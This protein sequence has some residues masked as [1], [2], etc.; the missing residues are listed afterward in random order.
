MLPNLSPSRLTG[1]WKVGLA[2]SFRNR[3]SKLLGIW[4]RNCQNLSQEEKR[5]VIPDQGYKFVKADQAGA[6]ALIVAWLCRDGNL[7]QLFLNK[8]KLHTYVTAKIFRNYWK[9]EGHHHID[10]ILSLPVR[11][12]KQFHAWAGLEKAIKASPIRYFIGKKTGL[13]ANYRMRGPTFQQ[14]ILRESEGKVVISRKEADA[15]LDGYHSLFPEIREWHANSIDYKLKHKLAFRN[16]FGHP[17]YYYG[18]ITEK[19]MRDMT[20]WIP[21]STVGTIT[22]IAFYG[23]QQYI[24]TTMRASIWHILN[25]EHDSILTQVPDNTA[26]VEE[27]ANTLRTMLEQ[28]LKNE[29]GE[30]FKMKVEVCAGYNW[31]DYD[32]KVNPEGMKEI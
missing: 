5:L 22:N 30:E 4:G 8:I 26:D 6:E 13:S 32:E 25:N 2:N 12:I 23:L 10:T 17:C 29:Q 7:R 27:M 3:S 19:A 18:P 31:D 20:A 15:F 1:A 14:D 21:Q 24:E 16:L 11:E 9:E 28:D